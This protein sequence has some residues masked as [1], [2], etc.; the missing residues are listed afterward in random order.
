MQRQSWIWAALPI[1]ARRIECP[2]DSALADAIR[3]VGLEALPEDCC[4]DENT[5]P[6]AVLVDGEEPGSAQRTK[7]GAAI[8]TTGVAVAVIGRD[9]P[10]SLRPVSRSTRAFQLFASP[11]VALRAEVAASRLKRMMNRE[12]LDVST[13]MTGDRSLSRYGLG[14]GGWA[15][16]RRL[17]GGAIVIASKGL[18][19]PSVLDEIISDATHKLGRRLERRSAEVFPSGKLAVELSDPEGERYFLSVTAGHGDSA[20]RSGA[21]IRAILDAD[22]PRSLKERIVVPAASGAIGPSRYVLEPKVAGYHPVWM[23]TNLWKQCVQLLTDLHRFPHRAPHAALPSE[24]PDLQAA[25]E[26][27]ARHARAG[28]RALLGSVESAIRER[29]AGIETG[30][31]HG[32]FFT[33]NLLVTRGDLKAVLDWE[34]AA[35]DSL[36]LLDLFDLRAQLGWRRRRGIRV[37]ENF[38]EVIW[39]LARRGGDLPIRSYCEAIGLPTDTHLLTGLALAHWLLRTARLGSINSR[40]LEDPGWWRANVAAPLARIKDD[41]LARA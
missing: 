23:S 1:A 18:H 15:R 2:V 41:G 38:T 11:L 20:E 16:R 9:A 33:K 32:D 37:G 8:A 30:G 34:W 7:R 28:D 6:D 10:P 22:P 21:V 24:W 14:P 17:P 29:V 27:L 40:R 31:G 26:V 39:P 36:P 4:S 13:V 35:S 12:G 19:P 3:E 25:T 5:Q